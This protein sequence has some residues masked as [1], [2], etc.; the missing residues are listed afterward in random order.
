MILMDLTVI[1]RTFHSNKNIIPSSQHTM[2][3]SLKLI[4]YSVTKTTLTDKISLNCICILQGN[5]NGHQK[6]PNLI[7]LR[8]DSFSAEF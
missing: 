3:P 8:L 1:Y 6:T 4:T 7:K 5:T 2:E